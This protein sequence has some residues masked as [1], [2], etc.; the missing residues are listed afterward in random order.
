MWIRWLI[1]EFSRILSCLL[2]SS[3]FSLQVCNPKRTA[4]HM[5]K[6]FNYYNCVDAI[7]ML[8][9]TFEWKEYCSDEDV[10]Y[11]SLSVASKFTVWY[12]APLLT[13][14]RTNF[15]NRKETGL[16]KMLYETRSP[17]FSTQI[18]YSFFC[19]CFQLMTAADNKKLTP[20]IIK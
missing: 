20:S 15:A 16:E 14:K 6:N 13:I 18:F 9:F 12:L 7:C 8:V 2:M 1:L 19:N 17:I 4:I 5:S 10:G 3:G 11:S